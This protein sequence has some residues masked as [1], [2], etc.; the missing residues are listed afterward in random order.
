MKQVSMMLSSKCNWKIQFRLQKIN[1][2][3]KEKL[4]PGSIK[5]AFGHYKIKSEKLRL[6]F[7]I[8]QIW[9]EAI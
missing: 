6:L 4:P 9:K 7:Y 2:S 3:A 1:Y 8:S 5:Q